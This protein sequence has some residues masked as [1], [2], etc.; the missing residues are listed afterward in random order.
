[1]RWDAVP[2]CQDADGGLPTPLY[3]KDGRDALDIVLPST[4]AGTEDPTVYAYYPAR[5]MAVHLTVAGVA[6]AGM[7][8]LSGISWIGRHPR[9]R[10]IASIGFSPAPNRAIASQFFSS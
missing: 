6:L 10:A 5:T 4:S 1:M 3:A 2:P 8:S 9:A 7:E